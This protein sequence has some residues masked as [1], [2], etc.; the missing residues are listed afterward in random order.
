MFKGKMK[1]VNHV[2]KENTR[3]NNLKRQ[4]QGFISIQRKSGRTEQF[5]SLSIL[6]W[7]RF[8]V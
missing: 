2:F 7:A 3:N 6:K 5:L 8:N 4:G 1:G